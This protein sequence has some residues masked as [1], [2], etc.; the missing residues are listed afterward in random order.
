MH[1]RQTDPLYSNAKQQT[2]KQTNN[3]LVNDSRSGL[4]MD[5]ESPSPLSEAPRRVLE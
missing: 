2:N 5:I 1:T 3:I 4:G